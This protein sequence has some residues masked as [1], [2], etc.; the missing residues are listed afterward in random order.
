MWM[1]CL[2]SLFREYGWSFLT[3]MALPHPIRTARAI[4]KSGTLDYS[5][6][7]TAT[8]GAADWSIGGEKSLVGVGFCMKP[9]EP[10]CPSGRF[11]HDCLYLE[12]FLPSGGREMPKPCR[13][14]AVREFGQAALRA[15][16]EFYI[17][18]SAKEILLDVYEPAL[19]DGR[20]RTGLFVI[21]RYS[22]RPFG[23]GLLASGINGRMY[24]FE[25]GDC[26]DYQTWVR[27]DCGEKDERTQI[28]DAS[29]RQIREIL[30]KASREQT[31]FPQFE[32]RGN[33]L[34]PKATRTFQER[35]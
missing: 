11:N 19:A 30:E 12:K 32:R 28:C 23:M 31:D 1:F 9:I 4:L 20:F 15:G 22:F 29:N 7:M 16:A 26:R 21:C 5:G 17:M 14:C 25:Q 10:A 34:Y 33:I 27:A 3:R 13:E 18:T 2:H 8:H 35:R 6:E 24:A